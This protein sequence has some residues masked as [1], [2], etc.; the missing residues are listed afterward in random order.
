MAGLELE[1]A[2]PGAPAVDEVAPLLEGA[3]RFRP[4]NC[5]A[6]D[7]LAS[8]FFRASSKLGMLK[9]MVEGLVGERGR[10]KMSKSRIVHITPNGNH[11]VP[12]S[13]QP[14][15]GRQEKASKQH[16]IMSATCIVKLT[17]P[18]HTMHPSYI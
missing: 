13:T 11:K 10:V 9:G 16:C 4:A 7:T 18:I 2:G 3:G 12:P 17:M 8:F 5:G 14:A 15:G 6:G 1:L